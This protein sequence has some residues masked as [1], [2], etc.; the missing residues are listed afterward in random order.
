MTYIGWWH[1]PYGVAVTYIGGTPWVWLIRKLFA[2]MKEGT[3]RWNKVFELI[4]FKDAAEVSV[5][6]GALGKD[7]VLYWGGVVFI[8]KRKCVLLCGN[9]INTREWNLCFMKDIAL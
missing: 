5:D 7:G 3:L 2:A 4:G 9:F 6:K 8:D 1:S